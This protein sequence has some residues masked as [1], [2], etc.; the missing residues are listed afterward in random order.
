MNRFTRGGTTA[1]T[2]E[3]F[4]IWASAPQVSAKEK[5]HHGK[6]RQEPQTVRFCRYPRSPNSRK[7]ATPEGFDPK[8]PRT[9]SHISYSP[10]PLLKRFESQRKTTRSLDGQ[11]FAST[12]KSSAM[13]SRRHLWDSKPSTPTSTQQSFH[14]WAKAPTEKKQTVG[15]ARTHES[16]ATARL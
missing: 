8:H 10:F 3:A 7:P 12:H 4:H 16:S 15:Y 6:K 9:I 2:Q 14:A 11:F 5:A 13:A 1:G